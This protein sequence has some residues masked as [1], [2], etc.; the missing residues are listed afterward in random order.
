MQI[1]E[2]SAADPCLRPYFSDNFLCLFERTP[3]VDLYDEALGFAG[4][5]ERFLWASSRSIRVQ[6]RRSSVAS[7][8]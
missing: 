5:V 2:A 8:R 4:A 1:F 7:V 6:S 3:G